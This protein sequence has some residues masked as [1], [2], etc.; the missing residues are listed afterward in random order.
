MRV[1]ATTSKSNAI[2]VFLGFCGCG[3]NQATLGLGE[4]LAV[5]SSIR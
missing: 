1:G 2:M 5:A 4:A 3:G